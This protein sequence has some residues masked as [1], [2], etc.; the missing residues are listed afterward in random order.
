MIAKRLTI[1]P[2]IFARF[3]KSRPTYIWA[4][5]LLVLA[6]FTGFYILPLKKPDNNT[7]P[8]NAVL[9]LVPLN[10]SPDSN[11]QFAITVQLNTGGQLALGADVVIEFDEKSLELSGISAPAH[12]IFRTYTPVNFETLVFDRQSVI[13]KAN[14]SGEVRFG[15]VA[16]DHQLKENT[17]GFNGNVDQLA[18][19]VF[20]LKPGVEQELAP[21]KIQYI[22]EASTI[23]SNIVVK[24]KSGLLEDILSAPTSIVN[25]LTK[26][27]NK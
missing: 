2:Q 20:K 1:D 9:S 4:A 3:F 17:G 11:G 8:N 22:D 25:I 23:D 21:I 16:F 12:S 14:S 6:I 26:E 10:V 19:L 18:I 13:S 5:V 24:G 27:N 15:V 7:V